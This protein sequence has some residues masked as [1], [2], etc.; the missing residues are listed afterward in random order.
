[1]KD[2]MGLCWQRTIDGHAD[3]LTGR[4]AYNDHILSC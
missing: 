3:I 4:R 1:M 2:S